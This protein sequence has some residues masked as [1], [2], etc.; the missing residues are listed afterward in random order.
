MAQNEPW[1][2]GTSVTGTSGDVAASLA[3]ATLPAV[4]GRINYVNHVSFSST[5]STAIGT[6][7]ATLTG[8]ISGDLQWVLVSVAGATLANTPLTM[9]F[10]PPLQASA[11]NTAITFSATCPAGNLHSCA[12]IA[13]YCA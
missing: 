11:T 9:N 1:A 5:G 13:G 3:A 7:L 6:F 2:E 10:N 4:A 8:T 12:N